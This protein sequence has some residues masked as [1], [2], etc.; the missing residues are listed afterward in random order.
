LPY[1]SDKDEK[2]DNQ[3]RQGYSK[4]HPD[5]IL[6]CSYTNKISTEAGLLNKVERKITQYSEEDVGWENIMLLDKGYYTDASE[7]V[8]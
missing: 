5:T 2:V 4:N 6:Y 3:N 1:P 7:Y 8:K